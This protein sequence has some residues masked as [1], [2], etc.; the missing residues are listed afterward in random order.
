MTRE[1]LS[2]ARSIGD[3]VVAVHVSMDSNLEHE[4]KN[5]EK[6]KAEY[7]DIRF[8]NIHTSYRS[9]NG[10]VIRFCDVVARKDDARNYSTTVLVPQ[11]VPKHHWQQ[12]LHNQTGL[13]LRAALNS[14]QNI[15]VSTF[16]YHLQ[17]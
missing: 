7:P 10:P 1:A 11:F 16:N 8:V 13:K 3:E 5:E 15:I 17:D 4:K 12:V 2:Y 14:R 9:I 6:F